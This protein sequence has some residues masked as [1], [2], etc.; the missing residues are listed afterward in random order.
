MKTLLMNQFEVAHIAVGGHPMT[1]ATLDRE[2]FRVFNQYNVKDEGILKGLPN[3]P[4][5]YDQFRTVAMGGTAIAYV[6]FSGSDDYLTQVAVRL[7][8][9][10]EWRQM[11]AQSKAWF[12]EN[13]LSYPDQPSEESQLWLITPKDI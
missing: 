6:E 9:M 7:P 11:K 1:I 5:G 10:E 8:T 13:H 4:M 12:D 2:E 3:V